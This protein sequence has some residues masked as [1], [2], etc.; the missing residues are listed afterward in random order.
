MEDCDNVYHNYLQRIASGLGEASI[1]VQV[2]YRSC[3]STVW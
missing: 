2:L 3:L 1:W